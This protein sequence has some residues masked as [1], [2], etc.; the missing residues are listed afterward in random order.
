MTIEEGKQSPLLMYSE[1][2]ATGLVHGVIAKRPEG[3][4][5]P[6]A[7]SDQWRW[8]SGGRLVA[9]LTLPGRVAVLMPECDADLRIGRAVHSAADRAWWAASVSPRLPACSRPTWLR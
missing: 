8:R 6:A 4:S 7:N 3:R 9:K 5:V 1:C 2:G